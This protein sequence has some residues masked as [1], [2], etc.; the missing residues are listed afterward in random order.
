MRFESI[1]SV[2][3]CKRHVTAWKVWSRTY[4]TVETL[5]D[6]AYEAFIRVS[7]G[8]MA[9]VRKASHLKIEAQLGKETE[10]VGI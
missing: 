10:P 5:I 8:V 1:R 7:R 3:N 6:L 9:E 2:I 4:I